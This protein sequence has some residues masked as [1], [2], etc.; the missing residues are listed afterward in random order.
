MSVVDY[1]CKFEVEM[2]QSLKPWTL[3]DKLVLQMH[4]YNLPANVI[5]HAFTRPFGVVIIWLA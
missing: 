1:D 2:I 3:H 5:K 4:N